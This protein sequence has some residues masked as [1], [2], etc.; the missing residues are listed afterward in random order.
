MYSTKTAVFSS[1]NNYLPAG[2]NNDVTLKEVN[3]KTTPNGIDYLEIIFQKDGNTAP[4]TEWQ[5]KKSAWVKTDEDLQYRDNLQ[6]G[7]ILQVINAICDEPV[8]DVE[9]NDFSSMIKWV[10]NTLSPKINA[11][12]LLRLKVVY[13]KNGFIKVSS[14]GKFIEPMDVK[15][16][17]SKIVITGRDTVV[18]PEIKVDKE[19]VVELPKVNDTKEPAGDEDLPF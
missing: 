12:K 16:E 19:E 3:V 18:K 10:K 15:Q 14:N 7:R 2:I 13:D 11:Q 9:L 1:D 4:M 8:G 17:D 5:N 6:F